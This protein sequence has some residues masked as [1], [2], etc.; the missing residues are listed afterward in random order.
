M[1][2][3]GRRIRYLACMGGSDRFTSKPFFFFRSERSRFLARCLGF[4][5]PRDL[6]LERFQNV[7]GSTG[8]VGIPYRAS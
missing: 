6:I 1:V 4:R 2:Y 8:D 5:A 3:E 7:S